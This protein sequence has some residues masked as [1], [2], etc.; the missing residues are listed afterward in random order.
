MSDLNT[1]D[2]CGA[3]ERVEDLFWDIN[4]PENEKEEFL[5]DYMAA[6]DYCA[7]CLSCQIKIESELSHANN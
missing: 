7:V 1:C 4:P 6:R 5:L 2:S 3:S